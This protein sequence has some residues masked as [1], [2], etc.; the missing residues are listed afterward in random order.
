MFNDSNLLCLGRHKRDSCRRGFESSRVWLQSLVGF[1]LHLT[2]MFHMLIQI[3]G[4]TVYSEGYW[5]PTMAAIQVI[6][7]AETPPILFCS[8]HVDK[9]GKVNWIA[10]HHCHTIDTHEKEATIS[11]QTYKSKICE[12]HNLIISRRLRDYSHHVY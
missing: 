1:E 6:W 11:K 8:L 10:L 7:Q 4:L 5:S 3:S 2:T 12:Q 9:H